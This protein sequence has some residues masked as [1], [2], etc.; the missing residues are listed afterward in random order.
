MAIKI[1]G[2][3]VVDDSKKG[4]FND[5]VVKGGAGESGEITLNCEN[6]SHGVK[7]KGPAHSAGAD[8]TLTLPDTSGNSGEVLTTDGSGAMSWEEVVGNEI[9]ATAPTSPSQGALWTDT[10]EDPAAP[11]LKTWNGSAWVAV[12]S[13]APSEFAPVINGVSLTE[14][15]PTGDRFTSQSFDV[16]INM[17][18]EGSPHSQK[19]LKGEVTASFSTYPNTEPVSSNNVELLQNSS[20]STY[21]HF[22]RD[23]R[24]TSRVYARDSNR[25]PRWY[26]VTA[27]YTNSFKLYETD[28]LGTNYANELAENTRG[29]ST[30]LGVDYIRNDNGNEYIVTHDGKRSCGNTNAAFVRN[31]NE[32]NGQWRTTTFND[33]FSPPIYDDQYDVWWS[34]G[35]YGGTTT[36]TISKGDDFFDDSLGF[37]QEAGCTTNQS[38]MIAMG[39][40]RIV[41]GYKIPAGPGYIRTN[42]YTRDANNLNF[43]NGAN[44]DSS[45][46]T[47]QWVRFAGSWFFLAV[48]DQMKRSQDGVNWYDV[49]TPSEA[50]MYNV[51][52][53]LYNSHTGLYEMY[54]TGA[55][56]TLKVYTSNNAYTWVEVKSQTKISSFSTFDF[57]YGG[58]QAGWVGEDYNTD[59][60]YEVYF[61]FNRQT[62]T[63]S[64][65]GAD[66]SEFN[67]GD[68]VRPA[69]SSDLGELGTIVSISGSTMVIASDYIYQAGDLVEAVYP[70]NS[71]VSTRYLVIE[72]SGNVTGTVGSDPGYV[73]VGPNTSQTLTFPATF[74]SGDTPDE[75]LP[76]GTTIKVSAQATNSEGSSEYGPSNIVTPS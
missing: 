51:R 43:I 13:A 8:Y 47:L 58:G 59:R 2:E 7:L 21:N 16:A 14:N 34:C 23:D 40:D 64:G 6:N 72:A 54:T 10:S 73:N 57:I 17:L 27:P 55:G 60:Y 66:F 4:L 70:T 1:S 30:F 63:L 26:L 35:C 67:V 39:T 45:N 65:T 61:P 46:S 44:V 53:L 3:T 28:G 25:I 29:A 12:G 48:Q 11:I 42:V 32:N 49:P 50:S 74:P 19:G 33:Y 9:S 18:V 75:E 20:A 5:V 24:G 15:D 69:G 76:A 52:A 56:N 31:D 62:L 38:G 71:A 41:V 22:R 37:D 68:P 36:L